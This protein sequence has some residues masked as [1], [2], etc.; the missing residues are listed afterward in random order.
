M[1]KKGENIYKRKDKR[2]EGRYIKKRDFSGKIQF[3]YVYG[4][5]YQEVKEKL[6]E[7]KASAKSMHCVIN[8]RKA[9][10]SYYCEEWLEVNKSRLKPSTYIKYYNTISRYI[11]PH[12][13]F[14]H[15]EE[16]SQLLIGQYTE[17]LLQR[18]STQYNRGLSP[19][20]VRDILSVLHGVISYIRRHSNDLLPEIEITYP[21][22]PKH[23]INVLSIAE[24]KQFIHYLKKD[25][26][27]CKFGVLLALLTGLRIGELCALQWKH[28]SLDGQILHVSSTLQR[29]Q[30]K[31]TDSRQ[32][33]TI[34]VSE[35]KS[36]NAVRDIPLSPLA[37][38][39]CTMFAEPDS[40]TYILT[41]QHSYMEP[42]T[43]Q[44][45]FAKYVRQ[46][47]LIP[48]NFHTLRHTF[49]TR[50]VEVGFETK[51]LSEVLGH[52]NVKVTLD[53]YVHSS[54]KLKREN[55]SKLSSVGLG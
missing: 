25:M 44:Y 54:M 4:N 48:I 21:R 6:I 22:C 9:T 37:L 18:G 14:Y 55:M 47:G 13:G 53:R 39:L 40:N 16:L 2:W 43:L 27:P 29:L 10:L 42:R 51:S 49:A 19:K 7:K 1:A 38:Q 8:N 46:S 45:R 3:G 41:G 50:C 20:T 34:C 5:T 30:V 11:A 32:K 35:P 17:F 31:N 33:T 52:S 24:Q 26:D 23:Q 36:E 15:T 12:I 28:I